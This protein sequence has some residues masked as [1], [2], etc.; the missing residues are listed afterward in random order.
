VAPQKFAQSRLGWWWR[1]CLLLLLLLVVVLQMLKGLQ[2]CLHQL[3]LVGN[4]LL[5][6]RVGFIVGIATL[7]VAVV[8]CVHHLKGFRK[9]RMRYYAWIEYPTI[10]VGKCRCCKFYYYYYYIKGKDVVMDK[11]LKQSYDSHR[12]TH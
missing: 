12:H 6:L 4:E 2:Y 7:T 11:V 9:D 3:I 10:C 5:Y 8:P 1:W